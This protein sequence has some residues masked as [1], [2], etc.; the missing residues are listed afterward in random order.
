MHGGPKAC[1]S[2]CFGDSRW[3]YLERHGGVAKLL[4]YDRISR[5]P[6]SGLC[7]DLLELDT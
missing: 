3:L 2:L 5:Q 6:S 4:G 1:R 7:H